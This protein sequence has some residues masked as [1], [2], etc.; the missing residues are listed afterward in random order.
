[1][2]GT[3]AAS[4]TQGGKVRT[5]SPEGLG[6]KALCPSEASKAR[7]FVKLFHPPL[8]IKM[9]PKHQYVILKDDLLLS[10][11]LFSRRWSWTLKSHSS[12][13]KSMLFISRIPVIAYFLFWN[14]IL[15]PQA[16]I[17]VF[18]FSSAY[19]SASFSFHL[20]PSYCFYRY[21]L[22]FFSLSGLALPSFVLLI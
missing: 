12:A 11:L 2:S 18:F 6:P 5:E 21:F 4:V 14:Q 13:S 22:T 19:F 8:R 16:P 7:S 1:M 10:L 9:L 15:Y 17:Y 20:I 3:A